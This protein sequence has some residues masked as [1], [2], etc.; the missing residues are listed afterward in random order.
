M[1]LAEQLGLGAD[2]G[3]Q[4]SGV[5]GAGPQTRP[6][7]QTPGEGKL[8]FTTRNYKHEIR[9]DDSPRSVLHYTDEVW[10]TLCG[11]I[12]EHDFNGLVLYPDMHPF[13]F[14]L[15]YKG[16]ED[17]AS[18]P[19]ARRTAV[20][21]GLNRGLAIAHK[22][23]LKTFMQ[24]YV[25]HFTPQ[26]AKKYHILSEGRLAK[27]DHPEVDR[28]MRYCYPAIFQRLPDLDGL[29]F[30]FE[31]S[32]SAWQHVLDTA[33]VEFNK[34][35]T[36][37]IIVYRLWDFTT[38]EGM[39]RLLG[40]YKGRSILGHKISDTN[41]TYYLPVADSRV[42]EW[43]QALGDVEW[44]FLV[45][46][47]H[48]CATNISQLLWGDYEFVQTMLADARAKGADSISFHTVNEFFS[49]GLKVFP[50]REQQM[51]KWNR[52]HLQ[53]AVDYVHGVKKTPE[54]RAAVL[55]ESVGCPKEAG[56]A[57]L[58]TIEA[59]SKLVPLSY[60]QFCT[61]SSAEG[62]LN[63][64]RFSH[65]SDPFF[66]YTATELNHQALKPEWNVRRSD[67]PW[68]VKQLDSNVTP[69]NEY[70]Y[71]IDY[72][73]PDKPKA[74][75]NPREV[76]MALKG[77][78]DRS[79]E[80]LKEYRTLAGAALADPLEPNVTSNA[81]TAN[82]M[83]HQILGA[84]GAYS[85]YFAPSLQVMQQGLGEGINEFKAAIAIANDARSAAARGG[86]RRGMNRGADLAYD[87]DLL[88][89]AI[90][91]LNEDAF[92]FDALKDYVESRRIYSDIRRWIRP[93]RVYDIEMIKKADKQIEAAG[94]PAAHALARLQGAE[95]T[96]LAANVR[97]W[98]DFLATQRAETTPPAIDCPSAPP[99][100]FQK[101]VHNH[102]FRRSESFAEDFLAFFEPI[103]CRPESQLS[104]RAWR[105]KDKLMICLRQE[106]I[107]DKDISAI[108]EKNASD[109]GSLSFVTRLFVDAEGQGNRSD[110]LT[111]W[112]KG[113]VVGFN[114]RPSVEAFTEFAGDATHWQ[115]TVGVPFS[116]FG[117]SPVAGDVW[118]FN[119]TSNPS[120]TRNREF[121]WAAQYDAVNPKI[122][123]KLNFV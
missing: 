77:N 83:H 43:K 24:H 10:D 103:P 89:R 95:H 66:F 88:N 105:D 39:R 54:E 99:S 33:I 38:I 59:T 60:Q 81:T 113:E 47:C 13:E 61:G 12:A 40:A 101:L 41:D 110:M 44:M 21:E 37:P 23:G 86:N 100:Q 72:V 92:P 17:V 74:R 69:D 34:M 109:T 18:K 91:H 73:N 117:R 96:A 104:F 84:I 63:R 49:A 94:A 16:F 36:P 2:P 102:C 56:M 67:F 122:M 57:L 51:V 111:V 123:G 14:I 115:I 31:S 93:A 108:W 5:S 30:N 97:S 78:A 79:L 58:Q 71:I 20:R 68:L 32:P 98:L 107:S 8:N 25:G 45:G 22:H 46:P 90:K 87:L 64:G 27:V 82:F 50:D 120:L 52:L 26:L 19:E 11:R 42:R 53:A 55:V 76:A 28:Y 106:G 85:A 70:Q 62:Y 9:F 3:T 65:I 6:A 1:V 48:N 119:I 80:A 7:G 29:Y 121:T 4:T 75:F 15:D 112:P 114:R 35:P 118:G 116:L